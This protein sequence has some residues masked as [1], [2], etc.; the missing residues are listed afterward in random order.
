[1]EPALL[2]IDQTLNYALKS[3]RMN[4]ADLID[5][6]QK[7]AAMAPVIFDISMSLLRNVPHISEIGLEDIR[8][9]L[10]ASAAQIKAAYDLG[11][12]KFEIFFD[13]AGQD[14]SIFHR[15]L[16]EAGRKGMDVTWAN[17]NLAEYSLKTITLFQGLNRN[18]PVKRLVVNDIGGRLE[19]LFTYRTLAW[20]KDVL[21]YELEY[22]GDNTRGLATG[23][24][25][26]AIK[27][28][29]CRIAVS[30]GGVGG[31]PAFEEVMMSSKYLLHKPLS[32][33]EK[34]A[35]D[36]KE[37]LNRMGEHVPA[38]KPILGSRIFAH[39]SGIHVDG[40]IKKSEL[41]EPFAPETVG[42]TRTIIIGKHS[43][44]AAIQQ[45]LRELNMDINS[46]Y[47]PLVL[48]KVR[49]FSIRQKCPVSDAQL[50][51]LVREAIL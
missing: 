6:K 26:G 40:V 23:N 19:S 48:E 9:S 15:A 29:I 1:M 47:I 45:K 41:Y 4:I 28:G 50:P 30:I 43:G 13:P 20:L 36:C 24:A 44:K 5:I 33:P 18:Y 27:S 7:I 16:N 11:C 3:K 21:P 38:N 31:Y 39:E 42:L 37:I 34:L 10:P 22:H 17:L 51:E 2:F 32:I 12:R 25:L 49:Q 46:S 14:M 8:V 35:L